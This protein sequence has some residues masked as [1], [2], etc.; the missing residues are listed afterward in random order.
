MWFLSRVDEISTPWSNAEPE[1]LKELISEY[2]P[3][4]GNV[5]DEELVDSVQ[6]EESTPHTRYRRMNCKA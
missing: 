6:F 3:D 1:T 5:E 4:Q 2:F